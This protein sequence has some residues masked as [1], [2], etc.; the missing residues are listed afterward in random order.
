M[1]D[2]N[3]PLRHWHKHEPALATAEVQ[4]EEVP[5]QQ[6]GV[7]W[8]PDSEHWRQETETKKGASS[9]D[10]EKHFGEGILFLVKHMVPIDWSLKEWLWLINKDYIES[11][12]PVYEDRG[13]E[14]VLS[15]Q[16]LK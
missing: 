7:G 6:W 11:N 12:M 1:P 2:W 14:G 5:Q 3:G 4:G 9:K 16:F 13:L 15:S 10:F 8:Q